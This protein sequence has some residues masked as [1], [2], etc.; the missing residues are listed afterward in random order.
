M[1]P[2]DR[3]DR[4][5]HPENIEYLE[6]SHLAGNHVL[7]KNAER[8][9]SWTEWLLHPEEHDHDRT[10]IYPN[11]TKVEKEG[12]TYGDEESGYPYDDK[13]LPYE[14]VIEGYHLWQLLNFM[15]A[16]STQQVERKNNVL[17]WAALA[18]DQLY[19]VAHEY[20]TALV[21]GFPDAQWHGGAKEAAKD[22]LLTLSSAADQLS[23]IGD[24]LRGLIPRYAVIIKELRRNL[25]EAAAELVRAFEDKFYNRNPGISI[26]IIGAAIA[27]IAGAAIAVAT[28]GIA[29]EIEL[30]AVTS[31]WTTM[32][33]DAANQ[34]AE[35]KQDAAVHGS[36]WRGLVE[37]YLHT[38]A[39]NM[40]AATEAIRELD[41]QVKH[42]LQH[43]NE[44]EKP[45]RRLPGAE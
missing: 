20:E 8:L 23:K 4:P 17:A 2:P 30:A 21:V 39:Q 3:D 14:S 45:I 13:E 41:G 34:V 38:Q 15:T 9:A 1:A 42:L 35:T 29:A 44:V 22:F 26:N 31:A 25:D 16:V 18:A 37:S 28:G 5:R 11:G 40:A 33:T 36:T 12:R 10:V 32:F 27:G 43:F 6:K 24:K 19:W 7:G